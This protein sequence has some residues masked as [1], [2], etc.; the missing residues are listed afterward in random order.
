MLTTQQKEA[1]LR[2]A[3]VALPDP[4]RGNAAVHA[5]QLQQA[6]AQPLARTSA[7]QAGGQADSQAQWARTIDLLFVEYTTA[8]AA[9]SLRD[10][11]QGTRFAGSRR[12]AQP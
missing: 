8:R 4:D 12:G 10:A 6:D 1:I 2:K 5:G 7:M 3:G 9:R 11:Q